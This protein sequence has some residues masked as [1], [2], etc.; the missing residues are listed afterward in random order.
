MAVK[1]TTF[2]RKQIPAQGLSITLPPGKV[3][4]R[5]HLDVTKEGITL[6]TVGAASA[7]LK[8]G[9]RQHLALKPG[10]EGISLA[11][12]GAASAVK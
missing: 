4:T 2:T 12:V 7:I 9:N 1:K 6:S 11:M 8:P 5:I 10:K 3:L